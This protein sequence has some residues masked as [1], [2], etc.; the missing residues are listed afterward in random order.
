MPF[1]KAD[2]NGYQPL[3]GVLVGDRIA[4]VV[5][6]EGGEFAQGYTYSGHPAACAAALATLDIL[7]QDQVIERVRDE[8]APYLQSR[9]AELADHPLVGET[10]GVGF[11]CAME[12]VKDKASRERFDEDGGAGTLCRNLSVAN[13]LVMRAVGDTMISAPPLV[14][15]REQVDELVEKARTALDLTAGELL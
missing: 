1:A 11:L 3:G 15:T 9:W 12:L 13:G 10:R 5:K 2:T 14:L 6:S 4:D 7:E 8:L